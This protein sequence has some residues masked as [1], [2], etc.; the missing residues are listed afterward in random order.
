MTTTSKRKSQDRQRVS[1]QG[2]EINY[3]GDKVARAT[4]SSRRKGK[5]A[6]KK[7]KRQTGT[8]TR[9]QV[10]R[11]AEEIASRRDAGSSRTETSRRSRKPPRSSHTSPTRGRGASADSGRLSH[12]TTDHDEIRQWAEERGGLPAAVERTGRENDV[13]IIRIDFP[14]YSGGKSLKA[15]SWDEFFEKFDQSNLALVYQE[16]TA[17]G[18]RS[19]F[20]KLVKRE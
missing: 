4:S 12:T 16:H 8:V 3:T 9:R 11:R 20:N 10:E 18:E 7:A 19:N 13:G 15:I 2:H 17:G 6:V 14:G 1:A 5:R